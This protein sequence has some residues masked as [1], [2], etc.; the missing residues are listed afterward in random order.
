MLGPD[1]PGPQRDRT[2]LD[3]NISLEDLSAGVWSGSRTVWTSHRPGSEGRR[4]G[5]VEE[6]EALTWSSPKTGHFV[7]RTGPLGG[8]VKV[9]RTRVWPLN[10]WTRSGLSGSLLPGLPQNPR[11]VVSAYADDV[12]VFVRD[13]RHVD[14]RSEGLNLSSCPGGTDGGPGSRGQNQEVLLGD[15]QRCWWCLSLSLIV[16]GTS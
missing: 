5:S 1:H 15:R 4:P 13:Q 2:T 10:L 6:L 11:L 8:P 12:H 7:S 9:Q 16:V 14:D 3:P